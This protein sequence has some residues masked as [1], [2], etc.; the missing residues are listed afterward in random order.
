MEDATSQDTSPRPP[1]PRVW[2]DVVAETLLCIG[3]VIIALTGN[4]SVVLQ[5]NLW[6][7]E[8]IPA[9]DPVVAMLVLVVVVVASLTLGSIR[10]KV[11]ARRA[12]EPTAGPPPAHPR[13]ARS[14][15]TLPYLES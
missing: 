11:S 10:L 8:L 5:V 2:Q 1:R 4:S 14:R 9:Y 15:R 13:R 7:A 12:A 6:L 3:V